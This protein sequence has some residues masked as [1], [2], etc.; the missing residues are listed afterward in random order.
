[1]TFL[2]AHHCVPLPALQSLARPASP[3]PEF[4]NLLANRIFN[5]LPEYVIGQS[6]QARQAMD[7]VTS[8]TR[9]QEHFVALITVI[10]Q[11]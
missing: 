6:S 9:H 3:W 10:Y 1:M 5:I 7:T 8:E 11:N 4:F 2:R